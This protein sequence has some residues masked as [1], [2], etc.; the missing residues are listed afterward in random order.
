MCIYFLIDYTMP[1]FYVDLGHFN[2][3]FVFHQQISTKAGS[4]IFTD[5][6]QSD[7][8]MTTFGVDHY[9]IFKE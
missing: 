4:C 2:F 6:M 9:L 1:S 7:S 8:M 5:D 3:P